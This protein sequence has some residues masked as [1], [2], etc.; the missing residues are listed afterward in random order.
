M[1]LALSGLNMWECV[2]EDKYPSVESDDSSCVLS[3][4]EY[5]LPSCQIKIRG[6]V[7][8]KRVYLK[9][10]S[11]LG[12]TT[13]P[14]T[15]FFKNFAFLCI[16]LIQTLTRT[17]TLTLAE[18]KCGRKLPLLYFIISIAS[19]LRISSYTNIFLFTDHMWF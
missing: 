16:L 11:R 12:L 1:H 6:N 17:D 13:Y 14:P 8:I 15:L 9:T 3:Y 18:R 7:K 2:L 4:Q 10:S 5:S 19:I